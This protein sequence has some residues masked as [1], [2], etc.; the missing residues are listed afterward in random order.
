MLALDDQ[1][2]DYYNLRGFREAPLAEGWLGSKSGSYGIS[3]G[4]EICEFGQNQQNQLVV[5]RF[6]SHPRQ[7]FFSVQ[8]RRSQKRRKCPESQGF[9]VS[10]CLSCSR[11]VSTG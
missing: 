11:C 2:G 6:E 3:Y 5:E 7:L 8:L 4:T 9:W 1:T 10:R